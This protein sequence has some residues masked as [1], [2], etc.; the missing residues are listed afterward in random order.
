MYE[1]SPDKLDDVQ[2]VQSDREL[3]TAA[4]H[5]VSA[6]NVFQSVDLDKLR[7][8][9]RE[10]FGDYVQYL[11]RDD[12]PLPANE[13]ATTMSYYSLQD[14]LLFKSYLPGHLRKRSTFIDQLVVPR[15]LT[16]LIMHAYHDHALS[17]GHFAFRATYDKIR[18]KYWWPSMNRDIRNWCQDCQACQR[19]KTPHRRPKLPEGHIL[20]QRPFE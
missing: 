5:V 8:K 7:E 14:G 17:G 1:V 20:V 4:S 2:P 15:D 6:T 11:V 16:G 3:F 18:H 10:Q 13:T 19:R 9:Q 12:A